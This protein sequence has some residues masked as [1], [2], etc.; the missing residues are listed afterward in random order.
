MNGDSIACV[1][2]EIANIPFE[3]CDDVVLPAIEGNV[4]APG[5][6]VLS[7]DGAPSPGAVDSQSVSATGAIVAEAPDVLRYV[8]PVES[9]RLWVECGWV[10]GPAH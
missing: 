10:W 2:V 7:D 3:G 4:T 5:P 1:R 6:S 9:C 8:E